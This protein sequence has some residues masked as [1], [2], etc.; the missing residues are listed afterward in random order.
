MATAGLRKTFEEKGWVLVKNVFTDAEID[1]LREK[2][3]AS[4]KSGHK[5]DL[6]SDPYLHK[7]VYEDRV[8]NILRE[9]LG[10]DIIYF[11]DSGYLVNNKVAGF[12]KD[13]PD[14]NDPNAPDW[15]G[16]YGAVRVG[17][18]LQ[19]HIDSSGGLLLRDKSHNLFPIAS[20]RPFNVPIEKGDVALWYLKT[21]HSGNARLLRG[22]PKLIVNPKYYKF[23]PK[24]MFV[25]EKAERIGVFLTY[26][27]KSASAQRFLNYLK[28]RQYG[29]SNWQNSNYDPEIVKTA[30]AH[31][32][33]I[34]DVRPE[35]KDIKIESLNLNH[36]DIP[37]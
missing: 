6:L 10:D 2:V 30:E 28:S 35:V 27:D 37:Y 1:Q 12:H 7:I 24:F 23:V 4:K 22:F 32:L 21:T 14:R 34:Q 29:V 20:G 8:L 33:Y 11:G 19:E 9:L 25:P 5:G 18:Y 36:K 13:N 15:Q 17:I 16:K 3:Y 31:G 26:G